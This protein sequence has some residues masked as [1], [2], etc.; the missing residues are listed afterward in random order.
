MG[1]GGSVIDGKGSGLSF[2]VDSPVAGGVDEEVMISERLVPRLTE[3]GKSRVWGN[4]LFET[5]QVYFRSNQ[6][7]SIVDVR[8]TTNINARM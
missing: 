2:C 1:E 6:T 8:M 4:R 7:R 5:R 3:N